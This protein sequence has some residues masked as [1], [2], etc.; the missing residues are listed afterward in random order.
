MKLAL[1]L[2]AGMVIV[3]SLAGCAAPGQGGQGM[4]AGTISGSHA[5]DEG[6][7]GGVAGGLLGSLVGR[8]NGRLAATAVGA[9][10]GSTVGYQHGAALDMQLARQYA[11]EISANTRLRPVFLD[12]NR[13]P[14]QPYGSPIAPQAIASQNVQ[15]SAL[16]IPIARVEMIKG[17]PGTLTTD[18]V[19][20]LSRMDRLAVQSKHDMFVYMPKNDEVFANAIR[21]VAPHCQIFWSNDKN[22]MVI[23][24]PPT[25]ARG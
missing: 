22:F 16:A 9:M 2:T 6:V 15:A 17:R 3:A 24:Q 18:A 7:L 11:A 20:T 25:Q 12:A 21:G 8:G 10:L 14:S 4:G 5:M 23:V 19:Q 1:K 13:T